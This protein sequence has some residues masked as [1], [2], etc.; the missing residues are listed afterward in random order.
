MTVTEYMQIDHDYVKQMY[1]NASAIPVGSL[2]TKGE[3][4]DRWVLPSTA[5]AH[6]KSFKITPIGTTLTGISIVDYDPTEWDATYI[7]N[8]GD[9][10]P[11]APANLPGSDYGGIAIQPQ[12]DYTTNASDAINIFVAKDGE[13]TATYPTYLPVNLFD[14]FF[15][16]GT[17][18]AKEWFDGRFINYNTSGIDMSA[19]RTATQQNAI[20]NTK[21]D[22]SSTVNSVYTV[23]SSGGQVNVPINSIGGISAFTLTQNSQSIGL[24]IPN[25]NGSTISREI[26]DVVSLAS[27]S[28]FGVIQSGVYKGLAPLSGLATNGANEAFIYRCNGTND[29]VVLAN[30]IN[31][32]FNS[33][34]SSTIK[35]IITG[36]MGFTTPS[37]G[38]PFISINGT[39]ARETSV[40]LDFS[41][42]DT[43]AIPSSTNTSFISKTNC[44]LR[45]YGLTLS[46]P[47]VNNGILSDS[48]PLFIDSSNLFTGRRVIETS[49]L[50]IATN[51]KLFNSGTGVGYVSIRPLSGA[52]VI[53]RNCWV[54]AP[55]YRTIA[56]DPSM[57]SGSIT[58]INSKISGGAGFYIDS[59]ISGIN[60][61]LENNDFSDIAGSNVQQV[62]GTGTV[63]WV[64]T[65]NKF[66]SAG[67]IRIDGASSNSVTV[68]LTENVY[69][70]QFANRFGVVSPN[71]DSEV[72]E[73]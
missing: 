24:S 13:W 66:S 53:I 47:T 49:G 55:A 64:I 63:N 73:I 42:C 34:T 45:I 28:Q 23:N 54:S 68:K 62:S 72:S 50:C 4:A 40:F 60:I 67:G 21:L 7:L 14:I 44:V 43:S 69:M 41:N 59:A 46:T 26:P 12:T 35:L 9:P 11:I 70:P 8:Y 18:T 71:S 22:K 58:V 2:W 15:V 48:T 29:N 51:C 52:N 27:N 5:S 19:Y 17:D 10:I 25:P 39:T 37:A 38:S 16:Y 57:G 3:T 31:G 65:G 20:D 56:P 36:T 61:T 33:K 32:F 1:N 6:Q 30:T